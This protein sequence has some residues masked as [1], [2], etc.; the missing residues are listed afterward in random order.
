M[1]IG[2]DVTKRVMP[3]LFAT[4]ENAPGT[5]R[6]NCLGRLP[7][8]WHRYCIGF[9]VKRRHEP[10]PVRDRNLDC[11]GKAKSIATTSEQG[12]GEH[13]NVRQQ[14]PQERRRQNPVR[15]RFAS[16]ALCRQAIPEP[17]LRCGCC[18]GW[19]AGLE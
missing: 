4:S 5:R 13:S 12:K 7:A 8:L 3:G 17:A 1:Q 19:P 15:R 18:R 10:L 14:T 16:D 2:P 6:I 11:N 9:M